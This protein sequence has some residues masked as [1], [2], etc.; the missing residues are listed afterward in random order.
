M[1]CCHLYEIQAHSRL[2]TK[3]EQAAKLKALKLL[4][5]NDY[6]NVVTM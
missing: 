2:K 4:D 6:S 5:V 3:S 1:K